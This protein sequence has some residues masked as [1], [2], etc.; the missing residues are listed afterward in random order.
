SPRPTLS[1]AASAPPPASPPAAS[2][3][4]DAAPASA[5]ACTTPV[6]PPHAHT[7]ALAS[8]ASPPDSTPHPPA[9]SSPLF[10][11][12]SST[13]MSPPARSFDPHSHAPDR[14][15]KNQ[16]ACPASAD[17]KKSSPPSDTPDTPTSIPELFYPITPSLLPSP[18]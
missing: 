2:S 12:M 9:A 15:P 5:P 7:K 6:S 17:G 13:Q 3:S 18:A 11:D 16:T 4:S 8:E 1:A 14:I 10:D